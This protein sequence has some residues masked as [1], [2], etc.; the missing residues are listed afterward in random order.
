MSVEWSLH[1]GC[2]IVTHGVRRNTSKR[3]PHDIS[4]D[5]AHFVFREA[6]FG[7]KLKRSCERMLGFV[8]EQFVRNIHT[9]SAIRIAL[10]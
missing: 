9:N 4:E 1:F 8:R 5:F 6:V 10:A 7:C 3:Q 2:W